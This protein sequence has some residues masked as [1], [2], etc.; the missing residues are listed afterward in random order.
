[1]INN[2]IAI[3]AIFKNEFNYILEWFAWHQLAGFQFFYIADNESTDGTRALLEAIS[4][5]DDSIKV[6]YQP[7]A[8]L[9]TQVRAYNTI[10]NS[11]DP[12]IESILFIDGDEFLI[13]DSYQN[14][15]EYRY[16]DAILKDS[17]VG[18]V[19]INWRTYGSSGLLH[20]DNRPVTERFTFHL[21]DKTP[22]TN[23]YFKS[24]SKIRFIKSVQP[25]RATLDPARKIVGA[26]G[27]LLDSFTHIIDNKFV[28]TNQPS[29]MSEKI[30]SSPLRVNHYVIKSEEEFHQKAL[31]GGVMNS[32][33]VKNMSY[34][35]FH[36]FSDEQTIIPERKMIDLNDQIN[37]LSAQVNLSLFSKKF[38]GSVDMSDKDIIRGWLTNEEGIGNGYK[39]SVFINGLF[40]SYMIC[41][42]FR[43]DV[44]DAGLSVDGY[45]G[46]RYQHP[47]PLEK[48]DQVEIFIFGSKVKLNGNVKIT[49]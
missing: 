12:D 27:Q 18:I 28:I 39:L 15:E 36:N 34:F 23:C 24:V 37:K 41:K 17:D 49:I 3:G 33:D 43:R 14:G 11:C 30:V 26:D 42:Y 6:F 35:H 20:Y 4:H 48:G 2:K 46:F 13:H 19:C 22:S 16:L 5:F 45:C 40:S 38:R 8:E 7:T 9:F 21:S 31:R 1:M 44:L 25:H 47:R 29:G 10:L 32:T